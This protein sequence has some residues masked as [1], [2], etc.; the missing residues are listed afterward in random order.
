M[1]YVVDFKLPIASCLACSTVMLSG[2]EELDAAMAPLV[3][4]LIIKCSHPFPGL[5]FAAKARAWVVCP[6]PDLAGHG[7]RVGVV[8]APFFPRQGSE[9]THLL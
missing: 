6:P 3:V 2:R 5:V 8:I 4:S 1:R 7:F 9:H